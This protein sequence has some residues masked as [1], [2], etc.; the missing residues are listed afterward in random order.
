MQSKN[1]LLMARG[2]S[3]IR[4]FKKVALNS[5]LNI[6][7]IQVS[8]TWFRLSYFIF[9]SKTS[10]IDLNA[11]LQPHFV[12]KQKKF[13]RVAKTPLWIAYKISFKLYARLEIAKYCGLIH[14][15]KADVVGVW[16]GQKL[17]SSSIAFAAKSLGKEVVYFEN[18]LLPNT[19]V[20]DWHGVNCNNS[21]PK[22]ANFY[23]KY[24]DQKKDLPAEL[25]H[26]KSIVE[27]A[28]GIEKN[29]L[30]KKYIFVPFQV[31][32]DS[33]IISNSPWI[34]SMEQLWCILY[35]FISSTNNLD[36]Y[37]VIK[38]HPLEKK[39]HTKLHNKHEKILFAN[40]VTTQH[41]IDHAEA[42]LTV[43]STV[44]MESILL[45]KKLIVL[46]DACYD[47]QGISHK[48]INNEQLLDTL[49]NIDELT[50]NK[51]LRQ[52]FLHFL[53]YHYLIQDSWKDP[54]NSH[55]IELQNRLLKADKLNDITRES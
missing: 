48:V 18:G 14:H 55:F 32:T 24:S 1:F 2:S 38:E 39:R 31:E 16:N 30:P 43:N 19:T 46:G 11:Y 5:D 21:L 49:Q 8:K 3:H 10:L 27:K 34:K 44:G 54:S 23:V 17:P 51:K 52:G 50:I 41:L 7:V 47:I 26:Q 53:Y 35:E 33:Q 9:L 29:D 22:S 40:N 45:N 13:P 20:C 12:K 15:N 36:L 4:Y 25:T 28:N 42:I 6:D 37:I